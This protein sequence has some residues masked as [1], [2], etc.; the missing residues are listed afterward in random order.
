MDTILFGNPLIFQI[1]KIT[2]PPLIKNQAFKISIQAMLIAVDYSPW[3]INLVVTVYNDNPK[4]SFIICDGIKSMQF[5]AALKRK[6][7]RFFV[8]LFSQ[9]EIRKG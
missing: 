1:L 6:K 4:Q 3:K 2:P 5:I 8:L 9:Q 7:Q